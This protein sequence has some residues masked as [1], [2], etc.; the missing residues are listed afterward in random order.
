MG[1]GERSV[2]T[3]LKELESFGML[4]I[5]DSATPISTGYISPSTN[6]QVAGA[7]RQI[8]SVKNGNDRCCITA[9]RRS[10]NIRIRI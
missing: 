6:P 4:E 9:I 3:Y 5:K 1:A 8:L 2:R 7:D 10:L